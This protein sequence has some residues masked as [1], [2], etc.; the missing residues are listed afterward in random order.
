MIEF[1]LVLA[2]HQMASSDGQLITVDKRN[3]LQ[4]L[5]LG[6]LGPS[7]V[8]FIAFGYVVTCGGDVEIVI[9]NVKNLPIEEER[10]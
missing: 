5:L 7:T 10:S 1:L 9:V 6:S 3:D 8:T 4:F 2:S